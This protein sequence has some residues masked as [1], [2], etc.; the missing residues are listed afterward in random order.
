M[1]VASFVAWVNSL[2]PLTEASPILQ[3]RL[4]KEVGSLAWHIDA[5]AEG[6]EASGYGRR[7][8]YEDPDRWSLAVIALRPGQQTELH[9]HSD[10]GCAFTVQGVER[11]RCFAHDESGN[12]VL[13]SE[14]DYPRGSG[15]VFEATDVHQPLGA[16]PHRVTIALHLLVHANH[17]QAHAE[18]VMP[19]AA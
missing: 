14:R 19:Q 13:I 9:D 4:L 10:W 15:Y 11:N 1:A 7:V 6:G 8:L 16:D 12:P 18:V 2:G 5:G 17:A 3:V